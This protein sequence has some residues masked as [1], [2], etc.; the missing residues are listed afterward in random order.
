[1]SILSFTA[2]QSKIPTKL[3]RMSY[4][5]GVIYVYKVHQEGDNLLS[6]ML[7]GWAAYTKFTHIIQVSERVN[8][9]V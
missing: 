7:P 4:I 3:T 6:T 5:C 9:R 2:S 1:M 8:F